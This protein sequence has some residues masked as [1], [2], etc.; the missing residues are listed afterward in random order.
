MSECKP[1]QAEFSRAVKE[2]ER[3]ARKPRTLKALAKI[4]F[5][6]RKLT[7]D[8]VKALPAE[9]MIKFV[10]D[11][12]QEITFSQYRVFLVPFRMLS[13]LMLFVGYTT[14]LMTLLRGVKFGVGGIA[15]VIV[16]GWLLYVLEHFFIGRFIVHSFS[17]PMVDFF[18][19]C[20]REYR[21]F[22][23]YVQ[24]SIVFYGVF[25]GWG[26]VFAVLRGSVWDSLFGV[27]YVIFLFL[28]HRFAERKIQ[29]FTTEIEKLD[30]LTTR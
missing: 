6:G 28:A 21:N 18:F 29:W 7:L 9:D 23:G 3:Q 2:L 8:E 4:R 11:L 25:A 5:K 26:L 19:I 27:A 24:K 30:P 22:F 1:G 15:L 10:S 12:R 14:Y 16:T 13:P 20:F 17:V